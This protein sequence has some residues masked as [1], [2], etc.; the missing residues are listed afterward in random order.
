MP[1]IDNTE[2]LVKTNLFYLDILKNNFFKFDKNDKN[3]LYIE[4]NNNNFMINLYNL[5][6]FKS[7]KKNIFP[8]IFTNNFDSINKDLL[9]EIN[10]NY[11]DN[12]YIIIL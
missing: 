11:E 4:N 8:N 3:H 5:D 6:T 10:K 9:V 2:F 1:A 12:I 7:K